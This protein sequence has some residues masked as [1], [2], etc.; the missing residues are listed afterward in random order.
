MH[1]EQV[2]KM[3]LTEHAS[4]QSF[5]NE[6]ELLL[7][8]PPLPAALDWL[9]LVEASFNDAVGVSELTFMCLCDMQCVCYRALDIHS[10]E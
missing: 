10:L 4:M 1:L 2:E 7:E 5:A 9:C 8:C 6:A 3:L